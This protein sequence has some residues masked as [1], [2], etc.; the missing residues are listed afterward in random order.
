MARKEQAARSFTVSMG[1]GYQRTL[2]DALKQMG[3]RVWSAKLDPSY[4]LVDVR[5][6]FST[7]RTAS[8]IQDSLWNLWPTCW[9]AVKATGK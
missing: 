3:G 9:I 6:T 5:V 2:P 4:T 7:P 1:Q 8:D